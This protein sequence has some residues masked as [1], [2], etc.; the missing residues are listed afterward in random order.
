[1]VGAGDG[2]IGVVEERLQLGP[3]ERT[4]TGCALVVGDVIGG[5]PLVTDLHRMLTKAFLA[6]GHP[7]V[8]GV[9]EIVAEHRQRVLVGPDGCARPARRAQRHRP[10]LDVVGT[11]APRILA[12][13]A[14][15]AADR[16]VPHVDRR[17]CQQPALLLGV[18]ARQHRLEHCRFG[19]QQR[20]AFH[21]QEAR[22]ASLT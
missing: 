7:A 9:A 1:L 2:V 22:R 12:G 15:E 20:G 13:E 3:G 18:P 16:L 17:R 10:A 5:V 4:P 19:V 14:L 6:F 8:T 11:P 21:Q